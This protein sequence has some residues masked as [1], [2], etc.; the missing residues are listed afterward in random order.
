MKSTRATKVPIA[1]HDDDEQSSE[2]DGRGTSHCMSPEGVLGDPMQRRP[3][4]PTR[5]T[6]AAALQ[7]RASWCLFHHSA[8]SKLLAPPQLRA[9]PPITSKRPPRR[10][11]SQ[12]ISK[13]PAPAARSPSAP[14]SSSHPLHS[15]EP[16]RASPPS[17]PARLEILTNPRPASS[18]WD[19]P[20]G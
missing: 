19:T 6:S 15:N 12:A 11:V 5:R 2:S 1:Q 10:R 20:H 14:P 3:I 4:Q 7:T 9:K 16:T 17:T 18:S 13:L 8:S